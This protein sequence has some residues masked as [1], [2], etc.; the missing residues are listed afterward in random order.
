LTL[1]DETFDYILT[2]LMEKRGTE[3]ANYQ[4]KFLI[5]QI[6]AACSFRETPP[7]FERRLIDFAISNLSVKRSQVRRGT[8]AKV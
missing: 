3:L 5:D 6:V 4:P 1:T 8:L 2:E 7:L